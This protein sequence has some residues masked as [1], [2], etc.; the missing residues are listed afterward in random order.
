MHFPEVLCRDVEKILRPNFSFLQKSGFGDRQ[1]ASLVSGYPP[2]LIKSV[3]NSL[4]PRIRFLLEVMKRQIEEVVE[5][6]DFFKHGLKKKLE[7][8]QKLLKQ[9]EIIGCSLSEM[10]E[11]N[12]RKFR[13]K[14]GAIKAVN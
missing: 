6:P 13:L 7:V 5:Y 4:E 9:R 11:C 12:E 10:L 1:I 2:V 14:F 8:R 3:R